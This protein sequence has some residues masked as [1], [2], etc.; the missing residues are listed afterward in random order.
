MKSVFK[1]LSTGVVRKN[2]A[3]LTA[4]CIRNSRE[5]PAVERE[6]LGVLVVYQ[7][8]THRMTRVAITLDK[9]AEVPILIAHVVHPDWLERLLQ[10]TGAKRLHGVVRNGLGHNLIDLVHAQR[11]YQ[12][13]VCHS[14]APPDQFFSSLW[15]QRKYTIKGEICKSL[16]ETTQ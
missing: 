1:R 9:G 2:D 11:S 8:P 14:V 6:N 10:E 5:N 7:E 12:S 13:A 16:P 4:V 15:E 3:K